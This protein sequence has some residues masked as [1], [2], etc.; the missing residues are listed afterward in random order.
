MLKRFDV[1]TKA[2]DT[3]MRVETKIGG[4]L[5]L[6]LT[7]FLVTLILYEIN[8]FSRNSIK[9][10]YK[11]SKTDLSENISF[12]FDI[13][14]K[15]SCKNLNFDVTNIFHTFSLN[16]Q[17]EIRYNQKEETCNVQ[18]FGKIP[19]IPGSFHIALGENRTSLEQK[20]RYN[21]ISLDN[22]DL[23][24]HI[25]SFTFGDQ[26]I[27]STLNNRTMDI[28]VGRKCVITYYLQLLPSIR[29]K[30]LGFYILAEAS[31]SDYNRMVGNSG[32]LGII[33]EWSFS[34]LEAVFN[35]EKEPIVNLLSRMLGIFGGF[36]AVIRLIDSFFFKY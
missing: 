36:S 6:I 19:S 25:N 12:S 9:R 17:Y 5:S 20:N 14:I 31:V 10:S 34:T 3:E 29:G 30:I 32:I 13:D 21:I 1:F 24:H 15:N 7:F 33:F 4:V 23:S 11:I 35:E 26:K 8:N 22:F 28:S 2:S 16:S 27:N 18:A